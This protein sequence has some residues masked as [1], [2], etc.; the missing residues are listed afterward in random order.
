MW[1]GTAATEEAC[2]VAPQSWRS[3]L[4][5]SG[6]TCSRNHNLN[7]CTC[8]YRL[9]KDFKKDGNISGME[10]GVGVENRDL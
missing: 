5:L 1:Q 10:R 8:S 3:H 7:L 4:E 2:S 6:L 9:P